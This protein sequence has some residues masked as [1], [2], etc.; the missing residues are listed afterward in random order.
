MLEKTDFR[1]WTFRLIL[2]FGLNKIGGLRAWNFG[3]LK[4]RH[5]IWGI[6]VR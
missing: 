1:H 3:L 4:N 2:D 6:P 5:R